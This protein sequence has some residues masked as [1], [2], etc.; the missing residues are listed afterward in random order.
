MKQIYLSAILFLF[1]VLNVSSQ[2]LIGQELFGTLP[3]ER[4]GSAVDI[5]EDGQVLA[6][7]T[8]T[9]ELNN[10][11]VIVYDLVNN[12][13]VQKGNAIN[14]NS[15]A[16][17]AFSAV[18]PIRISNDGNI[19][20][21]PNRTDED[22]NR[23]QV[24]E[25]Q[26]NDWV[27]KGNDIFTNAEGNDI[28]VDINADG[29]IV[30]IGSASGDTSTDNGRI[31]SARVYR[32]ASNTWSQIGQLIE[33]E[34]LNDLLGWSVALNASGDIFAVS[35]IG[36]DAGSGFGQV[37]VF[38]NQSDTWIQIG[39]DIDGAVPSNSGYDIKMNAEGNLIAVGIP[40]N[41]EVNTG[42]GGIKMYQNNLG[43]WEQVG[44]EING[45]N[46]IIGFGEEIAL[47]SD[48]TILVASVH[49]AND[50]GLNSGKVI[51]FQNL[52][53]VWEEVGV[54]LGDFNTHFFG[55]SIDLNADGTILAVGAEGLGQNSDEPGSVRVYDI[56][57]ILTL[58]VEEQTITNFSLYPNPTKGQFTIQLENPSE[59]K[60]INIY[61]N[62][63]QLVLT[64]IETTI[65]TS[66]L[67]SGLY[68]V[69][70]NTSKGKG[71]KKLIIE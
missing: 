61:N 60:N 67:G 26:G 3:Q 19:I 9:F 16:L 50:N 7:R 14:V 29:S 44:D 56:S 27:Q 22:T 57:S 23:V 69:E 37:K 8:G 42:G 70:V 20:A 31:G 6:V 33:G 52:N 63:G 10:N 59:L 25:F 58:S 41:S 71:T 43:N 54:I 49:R 46:P 48:G 53:N 32:Y 18:I 66:Q 21:I 5:S 17:M 35:A 36:H 51:I 34:F 55:I 12:L 1:T 68:I 47:N 2:T 24:F 4:F 13:W 65:S 28:S 39:S 64:S 11:Q 40:I 30:A 15:P 38:E 45:S 62:L